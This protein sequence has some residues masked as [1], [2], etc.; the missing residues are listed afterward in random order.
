M[1]AFFIIQNISQKA[2]LVFS[3]LR[4]ITYIYTQYYMKVGEHNVA[5]AF[6]LNFRHAAEIF[7]GASDYLTEAHLDW[8]FMPLNFGFET[9]LME[10]AR[11]GQ[12]AGTLGTFVS[13]G[14]VQGLLKTGVPAINMFNFSKI[15]VV[16]TV[17]PDDYTTGLAAA[18]HLLAQGAQS[19]AFLGSDGVYYTRLRAAGFKTGLARKQIVPLQLQ[20]GPRLAEQLAALKNH[21][22]LI[23]I[24]CSNDL[25]A[26]E[27]IILARQT[28]MQCGKD[29]LVVG[30]DNDPSESIFAGIGISSFKHPIR[31]TG[32]LAARALHETLRD[33]Q[34]SVDLQLKKETQLIPRASSLA[35]NRARIGQQAANYIRENIANPELDAA[36]LAQRVGVSR[37]S[38]E[39]ATQEQFKTSPYQMITRAR[40]ELAQ[41]LLRSTR[42]PIMEV[43]KRSGYPE[44]HH[45]SAWFKKQCQVA[46]KVYRDRA[47]T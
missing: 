37:R 28:G 21:S 40:L 32:Y 14:W 45:F 42:L 15:E 4:I 43:G 47:R 35:S 23:G 8:Q 24:F 41:Q 9:R 19:F 26:R 17:S 34:P 7:S 13:D 46:P 22:E 18:E 10:L 12:L 33:G 6:D 5:I 30:V 29:I 44:A 38:L 1:S 25:A 3:Y 16:P 11:S 39:L 20:P 2:A 36:A 27:L 31:E